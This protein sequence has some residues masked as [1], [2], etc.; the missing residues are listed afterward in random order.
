MNNHEP[1]ERDKGFI[2][3]FAANFISTQVL[4]EP[5][6]RNIIDAAAILIEVNQ[7]TDWRYDGQRVEGETMWKA[8]DGSDKLCKVIPATSTVLQTH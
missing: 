1:D 8:S 7:G 6:Y 2:G 3:M 5:Y 4:D